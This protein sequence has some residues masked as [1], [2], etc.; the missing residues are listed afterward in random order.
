MIIY[1]HEIDVIR[2]M[3]KFDIDCINKYIYSLN[4]FAFVYEILKA[5]IYQPLDLKTEVWFGKFGKSCASE[6][7]SKHSGF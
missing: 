5:T 3:K 4:T 2:H 7:P 6:S 1:N